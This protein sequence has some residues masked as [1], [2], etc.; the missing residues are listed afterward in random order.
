MHHF[1]RLLLALLCCCGSA[2]GAID[3]F[4]SF[5]F[6]ANTA[7]R[8]ESSLAA[9][10]LR[11]QLAGQEIAGGHAFAKHAGEFGFTNP[12][13]M[14]THVEGV[15]T[16]PSAMRSLSGGR[17]AFWDNG[18]GSVVIRNPSAV[19]GGTTFIPKNGINYFNGLR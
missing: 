3:E 9:P 12:A 14:A 13:Q 2:H 1:I 4:V 17:T 11:N 15:M 18:T 7:V 6:A 19:D 5:S 16:N 10:L 8:A